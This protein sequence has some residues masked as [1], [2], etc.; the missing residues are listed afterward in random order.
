M[1]PA[2]GFIS[3]KTAAVRAVYLILKLMNKVLYIYC[4][5]IGLMIIIILYYGAFKVNT[6]YTFKQDK[7]S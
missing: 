7:S 1:I 5:D 2:L 4:N 6:K 3:S